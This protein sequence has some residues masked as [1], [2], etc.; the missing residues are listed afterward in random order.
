[1]YG[2]LIVRF[3]CV[4]LCF[5]FIERRVKFSVLI[6]LVFGIRLKAWL[7]ETGWDWECLEKDDVFLIF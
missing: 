1:M 6:R 4:I 2:E 7:R 3:E 5:C